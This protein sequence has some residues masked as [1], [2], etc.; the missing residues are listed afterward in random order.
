MIVQ[1]LSKYAWF[2][3]KLTGECS[4]ECTGK[5]WSC[6]ANEQAPLL[7][8]IARLT[9]LQRGG[10]IVFAMALV[11]IAPR[12]AA[13]VIGSNEQAD[14]KTAQADVSAT[15]LVVFDAPYRVGHVP[16]LQSS[17]ADSRDRQAL[18]LWNTGGKDGKFHPLP[19]IIVDG[20]SVKGALDS[21]TVLRNAR[22]KGYGIIRGCYDPALVRQPDIG[23]KLKLRFDVRSS[24]AVRRVR[25]IGKSP[26]DDAELKNCFVANW[27]KIQF[28]RPRRGQAEV[29][30]EI[31]MYPGDVPMRAHAV[32]KIAGAQNTSATAL[33]GTPQP[34]VPTWPGT[35]DLAKAHALI[36][37][38]AAPMLTQ[39]FQDAVRRV[40]GLWG[41]IAL[42][43]SV[44]QNGTIL[45]AEE[46]ESAFPDAA[47]THCAKQAVVGIGLPVPVGGQ[48]R[49]VIP[50]RL[51]NPPHLSS[52]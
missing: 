39:C 40:P 14:T 2:A 3:C 6:A 49:V 13:S 10:Q 27:P 33:S 24:G 26:A 38:H 43:I 34:A 37:H 20:V 52:K 35:V 17:Q 1:L 46:T 50:I 36:A 5:T 45:D 30:L 16:K 21:K 41:R 19:R 15:V 18:A 47:T 29:T 7:P 4:G 51:G 25:V 11:T 44:A 9:L 32:T 12:V 48:S 8:S 28:A 31:A 23:G 42:D 22:S